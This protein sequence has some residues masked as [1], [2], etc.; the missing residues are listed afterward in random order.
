MAL[1]DRERNF[2]DALA[3]NLQAN[4]LANASA[5][6]PAPSSARLDNCPD[7]EILAAYH[8]R[9]L[10]TDEMILRKEH[11]ASCLPCQEVL[12][13]LE[14]TE[15][16]PFALDGEAVAPRVVAVP[17]PQ[18]LLA[19]RESA[20]PAAQATAARPNFPVETLRR[21][22]TWR[23][24]VPAGALAAGLL[25][26]FAIKGTAPQTGF[27]LAKNQAKPA[28]RSA[29]APPPTNF[30]KDK[31][32]NLQAPSAAKTDTLARSAATS[33]DEMGAREQKASPSGALKTPRD[34]GQSGGLVI[35]PK[36]AQTQSRVLPRS[37]SEHNELAREAAPLPASPAPATSDSIANAGTIA[38]SVP[39]DF[40]KE[41]AASGTAGAPA[42]EEA[43]ANRGGVLPL[44]KAADLPSSRNP[45]LVSSP[46]GEVMWR[47]LPSGMVQRSADAGATWTLQ[48][49]GVVVDLL[50]GSAPSNRICWVVGRGGTVLLTTDG[51]D[52]WLKISAPSTDDITTVFG[53]DAQQ[54]TITTAKN[55]SYKTTN[56]GTS[57]TA[58]PN[59]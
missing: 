31:S 36:Q 53:V 25:M 41:S 55:N 3:R 46:E 12:A 14:A 39:R 51:G 5:G 11:M 43:Q 29:P 38:R 4:L 59:P 7:A 30:A 48:K 16:I 20:S 58:V 56:G 37:P 6:T 33:L 40:K 49:T 45:R 10:D 21:F 34:D 13:Q 28:P 44:R 50:A 32:A 8:E 35:S 27:Q 24:L 57:W 26:W 2:E 47:L 9:L 54:A 52:H 17:H 1:D 42:T 15:G 22:A 23:W 19:A 18:L